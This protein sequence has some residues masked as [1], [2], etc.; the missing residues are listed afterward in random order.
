MDEPQISDSSSSE[1]VGSVAEAF[2]QAFAQPSEPSEP[3]AATEPPATM[4]QQSG[5]EQQPDQAQAAEA[6]ELPEFT[7]DDPAPSLEKLYSEEELR[8][9]AESDPATAWDYA[10]QANQYLQSNLQTIQ[11]IQ[12]AA[13][14]VGSTEA[15]LTLGELGAALFQPGET[16]P[17]TV[18]QSLLKLQEAYP[19]PEQGPMNQIARAMVEYRAPEMLS[20]M[21][22]QLPAFLNGTHP[23]F[24]L[25]IYQPQN[26][27]DRYQAQKY[28]DSLQQ[29]RVALLEALA[30]AVYE[31]FGNK[32]DLRDQ[33]KLVGP[34]GEFYGL[35]DNTVDKEIR[36]DLPPELQPIYDQLSPTIRG[37]LNMATRDELLD[38]LTQRKVAADAQARLAEVERQNAEQVQKINER[39]EQ[40]Q[41]EQADARA[42]NWEAGVEEYVANRLTQ[43]Y[44]LETYPAQIIQMQLKGFMQSDPAA[45]AVYEK[46]KEAAKAGNVPLLS[47]LEGD[48]SRHAETAIRRF[49]GD[50]QKATG[51]RV[52]RSA[53]PVAQSATR[54]TV[55][56]YSGARPSQ[57][58]DADDGEYGSVADEFNQAFKNLSPYIGN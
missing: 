29:Q 22:D 31:H 24:D 49:L 21:G 19:D 2:N 26:E 30:P 1:P 52:T 28:I 42:A 53:V 34:E 23:Y 55:P 36:A 27:T 16:T 45:K 56:L 25:S 39:I 3:P 8:Q 20:E 51:Q 7:L 40:Q 32:F 35:A 6:D 58:N 12:R 47:R 43:T 48:L 54:K 18:Y 4:T 13:E 44:K 11:E 46:A 57:G 50:W 5:D 14:S 37:R 33:Y 9:L 17:A 10:V 38:N 15:L 41:R